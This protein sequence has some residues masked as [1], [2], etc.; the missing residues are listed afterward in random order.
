MAKDKKNGKKSG[1]PPNDGQQN[2][3]HNTQKE[4]LGQNTKK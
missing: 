4:A 3:G 2:Q 1:Q